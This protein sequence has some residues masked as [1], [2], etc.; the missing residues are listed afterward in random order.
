MPT[1]T[2]VIPSRRSASE[3]FSYLATFSNAARWDPG[4]ISA[5]QL[6]P[7]PI[8]DG[9]RFRL[10]V[11]L[12]GVAMRLTYEVAD[13]DPPRQLV[14]SARHWLLSSVD[15]ITISPHDNGAEVAYEAT[16][17]LARPLRLLDPLLARGFAKTASRAA[18][19]LSAVLS[20]TPGRHSA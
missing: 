13:Y 11:K 14:L 4:V 12:P 3:T 2:A 5:V 10:A 7:G 15:R 19:G 20:E 16:V 1:Y 17:T 9:T 6:D 8:S 18:A